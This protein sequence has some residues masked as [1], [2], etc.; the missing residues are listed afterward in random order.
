MPRSPRT[1]WAPDPTS[2]RTIPRPWGWK[3]TAA[4]VKTRDGHQCTVTLANGARCPVTTGLEVDHLDDPDDHTLDNLATKCKAH[5]AS[6]TG[7]QAR[8]VQLARAA[9]AQPTRQHPG[10]TT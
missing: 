8:A 2:R 4:A 1:H 9:A 6:K 3:R 7:R 10:L 5:H